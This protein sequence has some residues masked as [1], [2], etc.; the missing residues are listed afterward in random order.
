MRRVG[1]DSCKPHIT[2]VEAIETVPLEQVESCVVLIDMDDQH[3]EAVGSGEHRVCVVDVDLCL[4]EAAADHSNP[5]T[6]IG[7]LD[8]KDLADGCGHSLFEKYLVRCLDPVDN[9]PD[10]GVVGTVHYREGVYEDVLAGEVPQ[11]LA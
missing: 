3:T 5:R 10:D 4:N 7:N 6:L 2:L 9:Q 8:G 11:N 1:L